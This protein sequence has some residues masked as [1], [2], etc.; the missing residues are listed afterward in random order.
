MLK[1]QRNHDYLLNHGMHLLQ[2]RIFS[3]TYLLQLIVHRALE[4]PQTG[5]YPPVYPAAKEHINLTKDKRLVCLVPRVQAPAERDW[6]IFLLAKVRQ[7]FV[8]V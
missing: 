4:G 8:F 3:S 5:L 6:K 7:G 1:A 2:N